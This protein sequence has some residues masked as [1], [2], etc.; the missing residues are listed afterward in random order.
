MPIE[1][2]YVV[3]PTCGAIENSGFSMEVQALAREGLLIGNNETECSK[4]GKVILWS[5]AELN[6]ETVAEE[7]GG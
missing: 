3:C 2:I 7:R 4:C 1:T 5:T 6:P